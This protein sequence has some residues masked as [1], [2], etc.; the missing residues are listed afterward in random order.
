MIRFE[1][2]PLVHQN[3]VG[4]KVQQFYFQLNLIYRMD[5][6]I[7]APLSACFGGNKLNIYFIET[8]THVLNTSILSTSSLISIQ[9]ELLLSHWLSNLLGL[10]YLYQYLYRVSI[11]ISLYLD[12][13]FT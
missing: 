12:M 11:S 5:L 9:K 8:Y 13:H 4:G 10:S 2:K 1:L 6:V 7:R 3:K